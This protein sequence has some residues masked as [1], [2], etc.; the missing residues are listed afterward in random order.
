MKAAIIG[1][2]KMGREIERIL[3]ERGHETGLVIDADNAAALDAEHLRTIDV[4]LE[5]TTPATA[6]DNLRACIENRTPVVS[7]TTGWT[8]RLEELQTLCRER[9]GAL[10]Y[11]SNYCLGV[12]LMFRLNRQLAALVGRVGGY[13]VRIEEVHHT[14]KKDAPS[15]TAI[16]LAEV[17]LSELNTKRGW[18]NYAPG[19]ENATNRIGRP[20]DAAPEQLVIE[21]LREGVV[22][23]IH[24]VTYESDDD[25]LELK[26]TIKNRRSLA[27][28][29]VIAAEFLCGRQGIYSMED[30]LR[31]S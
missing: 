25:L 19:I 23:G 16:T 13:D 18:V 29:A 4:A 6:Y 11:A 30:L 22:P 15:G 20:E 2:G 8:S 12:N 24:T 27:M 3:L 9:G 28:G 31:N 10:F 21:S 5:F 1:Y 17:I 7:G 26:H 14:Q